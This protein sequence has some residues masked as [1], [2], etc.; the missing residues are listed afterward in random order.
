MPINQWEFADSPTVADIEEWRDIAITDGRYQVSSFGRVRRAIDRSGL[1]CSR[2]LKPVFGTIAYPTVH[3]SMDG[4]RKRATIHRLVATAFIPNPGNLPQVNHKDENPANNRADNL[5]W[6]TELYNHN[7]GTLR[8]RLMK[9]YE[10]PILFCGIRYRSIHD[11]AR[12][13][14][15]TRRTISRNCERITA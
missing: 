10:N 6:C 11:C 2:V 7:Y 13:T 12:Q 5:E 1:R 8:E 4:R 15:H 3:F 14:G 9:Y